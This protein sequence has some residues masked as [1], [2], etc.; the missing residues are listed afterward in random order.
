[1]S[2][3]NVLIV[4]EN[5]ADANLLLQALKDGGF[6]PEHS[7]VDNHTDFDKAIDEGS[8]DILICDYNSAKLNAHNVLASLEKRKL[9]LPVF[10]VSSSASEEDAVTAMRMGAQDFISKNNLARLIPALERELIEAENRR[11]RFRAEQE[12]AE[13]QEQLRQSQKLEAI[14]RLASGVAHD[15]NN[16]LGTIL[17]R[18]DLL[19]EGLPEKSQLMVEVDEIESA[20][21]SATM[22]T[23]QL[24]AFARKQNLRLEPTDI[25][26]VL[27][28]TKSLL[29]RSLGA[30]VSISCELSE[31][32]PAVR[33]DR[34]QLE[35]V[36][37]NLAINARDA[38]PKGG[39]LKIWTHLMSV[40]EV[41]ALPFELEAVPHVVLTVADSGTGIPEE[42]RKNIFEPFFTTKDSGKGTGL[43][44]ATVY[45]V[46]KQSN[47]EIA[48]HSVEGEGTTFDIYLPALAEG[49]Q[50]CQ[51]PDSELTLPETSRNLTGDETILVV[52][53]DDS[54]RG[55]V[56][57]ILKRQGYEVLG[58]TSGEVALK[59]ARAPVQKIDLL[60]ADIVLPGMDGVRLA[61]E[62]SEFQPDM[63]KLFISGHGSNLYRSKCCLT[64]DS[65]FM[66]KPFRPLALCT[67]V[68]DL[69]DRNAKEEKVTSLR[70]RLMIIDDEVSLLSAW[71]V[72]FEHAGFDVA[73]ASDGVEA[74]ECFKGR[75]ADVVVTDILMPGCDGFQTMEQLRKLDKK[76]PIIA[77]SGG[78]PLVQA[79]GLLIEAVGK[80][81]ST[82]LEKPFSCKVMLEA[83]KKV[84]AE[85]A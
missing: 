64:D 4:E 40:D 11:A 54:Y 68:R 57:H 30:D 37:L 84:L 45:G 48:V 62:L 38:M 81:A 42:V 5:I 10:I 2:A 58:A 22:L 32:L 15:F 33:I 27:T 21:E 61:S 73:C 34:T 50:S 6:E 46:V 70:P 25:N 13:A 83:V 55:L 63:Q 71:R 66:Q 56:S 44:L 35:Q 19:R 29:S 3:L 18:C 47:G 14:G 26:Q 53:D 72:F 39:D 65:A 76:V 1:M 43:G 7:R 85:R 31:K 36:I 67:C 79:G 9:K 69:L 23:R 8:F 51:I 17:G 60:I 75:A 52:E 24:L 80:G 59:I 78:N 82:V 77:I 12:L 41:L 74:I 20:A 28:N 49:T 16:L